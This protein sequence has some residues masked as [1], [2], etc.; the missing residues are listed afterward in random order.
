[1][2]HKIGESA[3]AR[4]AGRG[5]MHLLALAVVLAGLALV[6][7]EVPGPLAH[8]LIEADIRD[9][10][11]VWQ[12]RVLSQLGA[13]ARTFTTG[14]LAEEDRAFLDSVTRASDIHRVNLMD[15]EGRVF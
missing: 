1:M 2:I 4:A 12:A 9:A 5:L 10:A 11:R 7:A 15:R 3:V 13:G 14:A 6:V 8:R